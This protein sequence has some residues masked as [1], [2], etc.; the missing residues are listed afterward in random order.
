RWRRP[1]GDGLSRSLP[2]PVGED[3]VVVDQRHGDLLRLRASDGSLVWRTPLEETRGA[4]WFTPALVGDR[5]LVGN[6]G[7]RLWA[8]DVGSGARQ[9]VVG[10]AQPLASAPAVHPD[11]TRVYV[12]GRQA[13]VYTLDAESLDAAAVSYTGHA[14]EAC[15]VSP[16]VIP[17]GLV[18]A[19]NV[20]VATS[21]LRV[22]PLDGA[23]VTTEE[24]YEVRLD[25]LIDSPLLVAGSRLLAG[26]RSGGATLM[27]I[28]ANPDE[29]PLATVASAPAPSR[30]TAP[31]RFAMAGS[32]IWIAT[33]GLQRTAASLA[34]SQLVSATVADPCSGDA[35][36]GTLER[37]GR[38]LLH[39]RRRRG[40][41][42]VTVGATD[43]RTGRLVWETD[44][45]TPPIAAPRASRSP[46]GMVT[47]DRAG[48]THLLTRTAIA[49]GVSLAQPE[50]ARR[51]PSWRHATL[52]AG[53]A[54]LLTTV[55]SPDAKALNVGDAG[56]LISLPGRP[57]CRP[58]PLGRVALVPLAI[59][60]VSLVGT[61]GAPVG[62]S[63]MP[64]VEVGA[65]VGWTPAAV[66]RV[67]DATL[68][69]LTNGRA[70]AYCLDIRGG[71]SPGL[72]LREE[73]PINGAT[74]I[75]PA[76]IAGDHAAIGLTGGRVALFPLPGF[77]SP[78]V[79]ELGDGGEIAWGPYAAGG[80][81]VVWLA[82]GTLVA[83]DPAS[84]QIAWRLGLNE[85]VGD[86]L[87]ADGSLVLATRVSEL[88]RVGLDS[89]ELVGRRSLG[90]P[91][92]TGP[93][94]YGSRLLVAAEDGTVLVTGMP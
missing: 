51:S 41:S 55:E 27:E 85:P 69:V 38:A 19:E 33:R 67:A 7:G 82:D 8:V 4:G 43:A 42:G 48:V 59:G 74:P 77:D 56:S 5:L 10:F 21:R 31:A 24:A 34:D 39:S 6:A 68:A 44:L 52:L 78:R 58:T 70:S 45:A 60:Q 18:L 71:A 87:V 89:G 73:R 63:F 76:A 65:E 28:A 46:R 3:L 91:L 15:P 2:T 66:G 86:P 37:R 47:V 1:I 22:C 62:A 25:G 17:G 49:A 79:V 94:A 26:A 72:T 83:V 40:A 11:G 81:F 54:G 36:F 13:V 12:V 9:G 20:G 29:T 92:G 35:F 50:A 80:A 61:D 16:I 75:G 14:A 23:R 93:T 30:A 90:Q 84:S 64:E 88:V 32:E 53:G 57:A